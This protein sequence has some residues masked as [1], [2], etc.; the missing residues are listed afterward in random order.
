M[1]LFQ[2]VHFV[3]LVF[4]GSTRVWKIK[5]C[6]KI[7]QRDNTATL[8]NRSI[9]K[10]AKLARINLIRVVHPAFLAYQ[11]DTQIIQEMYLAYIAPVVDMSVSYAQKN[12]CCA[13]G[14]SIRQI[15]VQLH[16]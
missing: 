11:D 15:L 6:A 3:F 10:N 1:V 16:A 7:V 14:A 12:A 5:V 8:R 2:G 9:A 4:L 13:P